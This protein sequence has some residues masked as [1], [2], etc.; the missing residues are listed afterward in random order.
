MKEELPEYSK[1]QLA[2]RNGQDKPQIWIAYKGYIYDVGESRLW[3]NGMHYE[4]W[5]GQD[6]TE[7]L[8]D[9]PHSDAV[10]SRF[11]VVGILRSL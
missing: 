3:K 10:F 4:H 9:A 7:E 6:L 11:Q 1:S 5:A 8:Y 2:L